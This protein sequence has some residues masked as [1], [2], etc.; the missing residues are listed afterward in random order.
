M[1]AGV[2]LGGP[3]MTELDLTKFQPARLIPVTGIKGALDQERRAASA[4][5]AVMQGVPELTVELLK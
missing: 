5:L 2:H 4:L 3:S 1:A